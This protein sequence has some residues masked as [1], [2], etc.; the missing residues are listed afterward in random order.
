[1]RRV[2][3][4]II[5]FG[6]AG[7]TLAAELGKRGET[8]ILIE[9]DPKMYGGTCINVAC[10]PTKKLAE[11]AKNKPSSVEDALYYKEAIAEK[12]RLIE[13][14]NN[15]NYQK[16][17]DTENVEVIDGI[18]SFLSEN[19]LQV[20][21]SNGEIDYYETDRIFINTGSR[22]NIPDIAGLE[23][24][25][26]FIHTSETL[27]QDEN[28]PKELAIIGDGYIALEFA[29]IYNQFGSKVTVISNDT[30]ER[31]LNTLDDSIASEVLEHLEHS[32]IT[33][34]FEA[35]TTEVLKNGPSIKLTYNQSVDIQTEKVLVATGRSANISLLNL[36]A[37]GIILNED[38]T[39]QVNKHLQTNIR[40]VYALGDVKGGPQHTYISLD[41]YRVITSK[42]FGDGSYNLSNRKIVPTTIFINPPLSQVGLTEEIARGRGDNV[43]IARLPVAA[44][45]QS[46]ILSNTTGVY[47]AV[48]DADTEH[49]LGA[50]LFGEDSHEV[51]NIIATAINAELP[52]TSL[53]N[54]IYTHPSMA[55]ALND[56][57][58]TLE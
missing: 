22:P 40:N 38:D 7:K 58:S 51:I 12:N 8:T 39:I 48:V 33:F 30:R 44:I 23:I 3:N 16:V 1:M 31:F 2:K 25:G 11:L 37:A 18:A 24:D 46:K 5:G 20:Q 35:E 4:A 13:A 29:S 15:A 47:K 43:L 32:G 26:E 52:Y 17:Q 6:K 10:I 45:P 36:E 57:F 53:A 27:I 56:L 34:L 19:E 42:L 50:L 14:L 9:K 49:I 54:Q 55:E 21:T 41:D 28:L